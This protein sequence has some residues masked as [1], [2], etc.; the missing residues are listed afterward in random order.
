MQKNSICNTTK[1]STEDKSNCQLLC[2]ESNDFNKIETL[3]LAVKS[4]IS[5]YNFEILNT[6]SR[7]VSLVLDLVKGNDKD[8]K[9]LKKV[10]DTYAI[11]LLYQAAKCNDE[12]EIQLLTNKAVIIL[13]EEEFLSQEAAEYIIKVISDGLGIIATAE[14]KIHDTENDSSKIVNNSN[15]L[16]GCRQKRDFDDRKER[17]G[18][19]TI[20]DRN[21]FWITNGHMIDYHGKE[22]RLVIPEGV[23][24]L[25]VCA[26]SN[27][28]IEE[29]ELP[30]SL[31]VINSSSI[32]ATK[33]KRIN[34][35][36][37][38]VIKDNAFT[39]C[40]SLTSVNL[41]KR[42][43]YIG[44]CPFNVAWNLTS[45][46]VDKD[47]VF[48]T[49]IEGVLFNKEVTELIQ[50]PAKNRVEYR[51]PESVSIIKKGAFNQVLLLKKL[52]LPRAIV[53]IEKDMISLFS[54]EKQKLTIYIPLNSQ[55]ENYIK[56]T[57]LDE[58]WKDQG[59]GIDYYE[60]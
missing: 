29:V 32:R 11:A 5:K 3:T 58:A 36:S 13:Q 21:G 12:R 46:D 16:T 22:P 17:V 37:V 60:V 30:N 48:Y 15:E 34:L 33:L 53:L 38:E 57:R 39:M 2:V 45:I 25:N 28:C 1:K 7:F 55:T 31:K 54:K 44:I 35:E 40:L 41:S 49:S 6:P 52:Y 10:C 14:V 56:I 4:I 8:I 50:F 59:I 26:L 43:R 9:L 47:N 27:S 24:S 18:S 19:L 23:I 42:I 20:K 51:I